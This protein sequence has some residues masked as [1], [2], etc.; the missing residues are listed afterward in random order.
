VYIWIKSILITNSK[1]EKPKMVYFEIE[2]MLQPNIDQ[3]YMVQADIKPSE[4]LKWL[5]PFTEKSKLN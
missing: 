2:D 3:T 5:H 1:I 4:T